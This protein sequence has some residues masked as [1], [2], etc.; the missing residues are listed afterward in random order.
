MKRG[1][2]VDKEIIALRGYYES[3]TRS[4]DP[5]TESIPVCGKNIRFAPYE[6][7]DGTVCVW[8]PE[9]FAIMPERIAKVRYITEY[10]P[11]VILTNDRYD[12]NFCFHLLGDEEIPSPV[13]L[14]Q[15]VQNMQ[16]TILLHA[17]ESVMYDHGSILSDR[18]EGRWFEY[19]G[20][21]LDEETYNLQ[22]LI[23]SAPYLLAGIFNCRMAFYDGLIDVVLWLMEHVVI[24]KKEDKL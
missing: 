20:F 7:F 14:D 1:N 19:K 3:R 18:M 16:D 22:F 24:R 4:Y 12:E 23:Y 21:T 8:I 10:R 6:L 15:M 13:L 9:D 17:P 11:P 2:Y 5:L